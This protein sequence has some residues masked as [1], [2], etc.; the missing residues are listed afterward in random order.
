MV[1]LNIIYAMI[2]KTCCVCVE[3]FIFY[4][5]DIIF[6]AHKGPISERDVL[7]KWVSVIDMLLFVHILPLLLNLFLINW[8]HA[9][10]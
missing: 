1:L 2:S 9:S 6:N 7:V 5:L 8:G 4:L 3:T 10:V